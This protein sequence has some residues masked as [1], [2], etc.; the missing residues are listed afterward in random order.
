M[1]DGGTPGTAGDGITW[2]WFAGDD[3]ALPQTT[4]LGSWP[5]LCKK[6]ILAG[7]LMIHPPPRMP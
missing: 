1:H 4:D 6:T 3:P 5:H 2:K 7:N